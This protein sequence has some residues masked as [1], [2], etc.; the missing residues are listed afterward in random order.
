MMLYFEASDLAFTL[1]LI[2]SQLPLEL[3]GIVFTVLQ[4]SRCYKEE[5][6][7]LAPHNQQGA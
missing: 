5:L 1:G 6:L 2:E 7:T 3:T 4:T